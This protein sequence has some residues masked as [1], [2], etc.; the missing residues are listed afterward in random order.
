MG[1]STLGPW[2]IRGTSDRMKLTIR[3]TDDSVD[4]QINPIASTWGGAHR[5]LRDARLERAKEVFDP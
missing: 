2:L 5:R 4:A 3:G 1:M